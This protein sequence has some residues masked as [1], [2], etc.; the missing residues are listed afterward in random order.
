MVVDVRITLTA[1]LVVFVVLR[2]T[3]LVT[4]SWVWVL[5]PLWIP[6]AL[7]ATAAIVGHAMIGLAAILSYRAR[8]KKGL[9]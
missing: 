7:L 8:R 9:P 2:L 6:F 3:E 4:W 1:L 5:A